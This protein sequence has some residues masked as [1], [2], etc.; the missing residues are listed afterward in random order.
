MGR[1]LKRN[2]ASQQREEVI[3]VGFASGSPNCSRSSAV[4]SRTTRHSLAWLINSRS[5]CHAGNTF[6][7]PSVP[8]V[9]MC[10]PSPGTVRKVTILPTLRQA[11]HHQWQV[12]GPTHIDRDTPLAHRPLR[13]RH[14]H[15]VRQRASV[16]LIHRRHDR[17]P[18]DARRCFLT[19]CPKEVLSF[20]V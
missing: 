8:A 3:Q 15:Q 17:S 6:S 5:V 9:A 11:P 1:T 4:R 18:P 7:V 16:I 2:L 20:I 13:R 19:I 14:R 10:F 12:D